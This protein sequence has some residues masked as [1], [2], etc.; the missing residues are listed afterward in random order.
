MDLPF[1]SC[2]DK[3]R[4]ALSQ[5]ASDV[6]KKPCE[7]WGLARKNLPVKNA[8][9]VEEVYRTII[10]YISKSL[11]G[12]YLVRGFYFL[13]FATFCLFSLEACHTDRK[14]QS[15]MKPSTF[16][17]LADGREILEYTLDNSA[18][19][20]ARFINYGATITSL[21][22]P[23]REGNIEDVVLGY[24]SLQGY[25]NGSEY[26]GAVV[27]RYGNRIGKGQFL[28]DGQQYQLTINNGENHLHGGKIGFN[29]V[30]WEAE[31]LNDSDMPA[32]RFRY[33]SPDGEEGY[34]GTVALNVTYTLTD[35]NELRID[36]EG[37]TDKPT[38]L[39]PTQHSYFNLS[40]KFTET[41][42]G[43][44][45][46]IDA[47]R[48][49]PVDEGLI[50]TGELA[51]VENTPLDFRQSQTIGARIDDSFEQLVL[52]QG[53]DHNWVLR[54]YTGDGKIHEAAQ[55]YDPSSG[56]LMT[57]FT[58]Q[59]GIQFYSGNFLDGSAIGKNGIV[60]GHRTGL[61]LETQVFP[62]S[63]NKPDFPSAILKPGQVYRQTT[64]Y[65]FSTR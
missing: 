44:T 45:L 56:R 42:L 57:V 23:D 1:R 5:S 58:D 12:G 29:K 27:G 30:L 52:G 50:P 17:V 10:K 31:V 22:V 33:V 41:I 16:G 13:C 34:P 8:G 2:C 6:T 60:Y 3:L 18:G 28:I 64:I 26:F 37:M 63:P 54:D 61:C 20:S 7:E 9:L 21:S 14:A 59:P 4:F 51:S 15:L 62:D 32:V 35:D 40:G 46:M 48:F 65:Q 43:H 25:V 24:D 38:I 39:N 53:Y 55:L 47:D 11:T 36:Y 49:T 19:M